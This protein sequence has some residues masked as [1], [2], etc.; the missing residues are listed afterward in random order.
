M[1]IGVGKD[2]HLQIFRMW[3]ASPEYNQMESLALFRGQSRKER[4]RERIR[5]ERALL[6][7]LT[8]LFP[9]RNQ[10]CTNRRICWLQIKL[11]VIT[12]SSMHNP[13]IQQL[14]FYSFRREGK[15]RLNLSFRK[16]CALMILCVRPHPSEMCGKK[17]LPNW[18]YHLKLVFCFVFSLLRAPIEEKLAY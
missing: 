12:Y 4:K 6:P 1:V 2:P 16:Q 3:A 13:T 18:Y 17:A 8:Q 11:S 9:S 5:K 15:V 7:I 10:S 14:F